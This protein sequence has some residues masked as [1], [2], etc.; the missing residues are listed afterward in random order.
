MKRLFC[1]YISLLAGVTALFGQEKI[2]NQYAMTL[3]PDGNGGYSLDNR[4]KYEAILALDEV[5]CLLEPY[6]YVPDKI[7]KADYAG[8]E[9]RRFVYK[10]H[11]GYEL[12]LEVDMP[13]N[14]GDRAPF[15]VY[16]HGGGWQ[17]GTPDANKLLSQ[18]LAKQHG[19]AG[20]RIAYT[21]SPQPGATI[22][23]TV[24]DIQD[25]LAFI[26]SQADELGLDASNY[27]FAGGSAGAH[28]GAVGA[29][30]T[31]ARVFVGFAG[32]YDLNKAAITA[33]ATMP[34]RVAYFLDK[35]PAVL[36]EFSPAHLVRESGNPSCLLICGTGDITVEHEQSILFA[37]ALKAAGA[38]VELNVYDYYGHNINNKA[39]A[40][41][42]EVLLKA[43][44]FISQHLKP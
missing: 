13:V 23:V 31:D 21:L 14:G 26:Q 25:A 17:R 5:P 40:V 29:M 36:R 3:L 9:V 37:D 16:V 33:K 18:Y 28:L 43:A 15:V 7:Q 11:P 4:A 41:M 22:R 10:T 35:D 44:A 12:H 42:E 30:L 38:E 2:T 20:V 19:I 8:V 27:G 1:L 24:Q 39:S 6:T 32:I 34:E